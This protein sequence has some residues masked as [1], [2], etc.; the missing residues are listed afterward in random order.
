MKTKVTRHDNFCFFGVLIPFFENF[1]RKGLLSNPKSV[2]N[3]SH[4][5]ID[6]KHKNN[7]RRDLLI[8][9]EDRTILK[10]NL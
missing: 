10:S 7:I 9:F 6:L 4:H 1:I 3:P 2:G 8:L 5:E